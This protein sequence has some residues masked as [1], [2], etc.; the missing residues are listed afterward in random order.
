MTLGALVVDRDRF[1]ALV[2]EYDRHGYALPEWLKPNALVVFRR[3]TFRIVRVI[4][5]RKRYEGMTLGFVAGI[6]PVCVLVQRTAPPF[7]KRGKEIHPNF[8]R[9]ARECP[10][11]PPHRE[12]ACATP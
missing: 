6:A 1:L 12:N 4:R 5:W 7:W 10:G 8:L 9:P 2:R 11:V 3:E